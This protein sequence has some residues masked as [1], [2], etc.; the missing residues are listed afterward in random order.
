MENGV[1]LQSKE[2]L[3]QRSGELDGLALSLETGTMASS[4]GDSE[5]MVDERRMTSETTNKPCI[6]SP[7]EQ[8]RRDSHGS[9]ELAVHF[10]DS[11]ESDE[12][13]DPSEDGLSTSLMELS[14]LQRLGLHRVAL[15][16]QDVET[17]F[18]HLAL[19]F[20]CDMFTLRRRVQVEERARNTAEENIEKELAECWTMLQ[21]L[22]QSCLDSR[23]KEMVEQ[24]KSSLTI[25]AGAIERATVAAEKL[26]AVHQEARMSRAT[27]V[28]VQH[29]ENLKRHHLRDHTELE[30]MKR[31]I[32][33][34]SRNRQLAENRDDGEQRV[35][36]PPVRFF[37]QGSAR[38]RVS[39]AVIPR[40]LTIHSS[41]NG[42]GSEGEAIKPT[43]MEEESPERHPLFPQEDFTD[44]SFILHAG[45]SNIPHLNL[46]R[47]NSIEGD[48]R[49]SYCTERR[50]SELRRRTSIGKT[51]EE[52][53]NEEQGHE[54][55]EE[56]CDELETNVFLSK[57][58]ERGYC[59]A[60]FS[61]PTYYW[62]L[63][64]LFFL[65]IVCLILIRF[66]ELQ[67]QYPFITSD[68]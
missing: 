49:R 20:R 9:R 48:T 58:A 4:E 10:E 36:H 59:K 23:C 64:W 19:A 6:V 17:A 43:T 52:E 53:A 33:Q 25:L 67:K 60:W 44:T 63:M 11:G 31:L 47:T 15:T 8:A 32:Q 68:F 40:Q 41:E 55:G 56:E 37:Q 5:R 12:D 62:V 51:V 22:D 50:G 26:G 1:V 42:Q 29:V 14:V 28:M 66:L 61:M 45:S 57:G 38:R 27:E 13:M 21:K 7:R 39:I 46:Q 18:T 24:L 30:E 3:G 65:G 54:E 35:K 16:E 34:N 2:P